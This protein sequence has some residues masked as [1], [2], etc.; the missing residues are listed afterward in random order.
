MKAEQYKEIITMAVGN[1]IEAYEFYK[2]AADKVKDSNMKSIFQ[3]LANEELR[4]KD[5]LQGLVTGAKPMLF[6]ES[7]DY[8][9]AETIDKPKL[10]I[11]MAPADAIGL[12]VKNEEDAMLMYADLA[13]VSADKEQKEM[14]ESLSRMEQGHKV[15]LEGMY[16]DMAFPEEW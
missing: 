6:D 7:K 13:K 1:E 8:K 15:R 2:A 14:F 11:T 12:A 16:T 10:S 4:H 3:D 5:F 9:I